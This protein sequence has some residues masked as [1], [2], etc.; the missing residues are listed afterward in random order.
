MRLGVGVRVG[1]R[2]RVGV[3]V[4]VGLGPKVGV[5]ASVGCKVALA[6]AVKVKVGSGEGLFSLA[7][8]TAGGGSLGTCGE[9]AVSVGKGGRVALITTGW[10]TGVSSHE[11]GTPRPLQP[12][13]KTPNRSNAPPQ[14]YWMINRRS[15]RRFILQLYG[16][17]D[18]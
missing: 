5:P 18:F 14:K 15:L 4:R 11:P 8:V 13:V 9:V 12:E 1:K 16:R 2:V 10:S 17:F 3:R 7:S 6:V